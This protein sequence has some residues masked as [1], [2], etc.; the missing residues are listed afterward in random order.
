MCFGSAQCKADAGAAGGDTVPS[1]RS[2]APV[3]G[4]GLG[5][6]PGV[7]DTPV[8]LPRVLGVPAGTAGRA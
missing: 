4:S 1:G 2:A 7:V 5:D 3:R 8:A 6:C